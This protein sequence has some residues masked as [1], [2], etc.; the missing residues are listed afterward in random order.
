MYVATSHPLECRRRPPRRRP[1]VR[2]D[3]MLAEGRHR[4]GSH[5]LVPTFDLRAVITQYSRGKSVRVNSIFPT[6]TVGVKVKASPSLNPDPE[7]SPDPNLNP[8]P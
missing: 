6:V 1:S 4:T 2:L 3:E 8:S 5:I 7:S